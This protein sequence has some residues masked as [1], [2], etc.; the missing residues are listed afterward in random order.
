MTITGVFR[1]PHLVRGVVCTG[2]GN[3]V[4]ARGLVC[5]PI[6]IGELH[7]WQR[8]DAAAADPTPRPRDG[9]DVGAA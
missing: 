4:I 1:H 7:G 8:V 9:R 6:A 3:F 5:V 2:T